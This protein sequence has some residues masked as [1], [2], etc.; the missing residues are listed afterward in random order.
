M[1]TRCAEANQVLHAASADACVTARSVAN[2]VQHTAGAN[3]DEQRNPSRRLCVAD[4]VANTATSTAL[5]TAP[6]RTPPTPASP[7]AASPTRWSTRPAP[8]PTSSAT[9]VADC[10]TRTRS[11]ARSVDGVVRRADAD[12]ADAGVTARRVANQVQHAAGAKADE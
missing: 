10:A 9:R 6:T 1:T 2:Q 7:P 12:A 3:T 5:S 8:K 4:A 11:P